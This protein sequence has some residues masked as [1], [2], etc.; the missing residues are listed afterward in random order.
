MNNGSMVVAQSGS[1][2]GSQVISMGHGG[3]NM[4]N[5]GSGSQFIHMGQRGMT[6]VQTD[7]SESQ[8][9]STGSG[10]M[11]MI[12]SGTVVFNNVNIN[13]SNSNDTGNVLMN[14]RNAW[15]NLQGQYWSFY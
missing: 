5:T 4:I 10:G 11:N 9:I 12:G 3:M 13:N 15:R 1:S 8:V 2:G 14:N 7:G 6:I